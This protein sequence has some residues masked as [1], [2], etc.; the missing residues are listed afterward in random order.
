MHMLTDCQLTYKGPVWTWNSGWFCSCCH[1]VQLTSWFAVHLHNSVAEWNPG[2]SARLPQI[3]PISLRY[4]ANKP[5]LCGLFYVG[6]WGF[7]SDALHWAIE[8]DNSALLFPERGSV[9]F[10]RTE[11]K[12]NSISFRRVAEHSHLSRFCFFLVHAR[13]VLKVLL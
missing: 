2:L 4:T 3:P 7:S 13:I 11:K 5:Y 10:N 12:G 8:L 9:D 1:R 6:H